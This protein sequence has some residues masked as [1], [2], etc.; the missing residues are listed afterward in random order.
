MEEDTKGKKNVTLFGG[1]FMEKA[2]KR[3][4]E[5]KASSGTQREAPSAK[6]RR[7]AQDPTDLHHFLEKGIPAQYSGRKHQRQQLY[8]WN[9]NPKQGHQQ[10]QA[11]WAQ[12]SLIVS[13]SQH[14][15]VNING[16]QKHL[17]T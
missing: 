15:I 17:L 2:T 4:E 7:Y 3:M 6:R 13:S 16:R 5:E 14:N 9:H 1:G 12:L 10:Q 11:L 8:S